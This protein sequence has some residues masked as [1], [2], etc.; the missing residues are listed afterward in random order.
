M[1]NVARDYAIKS[2]GNNAPTE[3]IDQLAWSRII[4]IEEAKREKL[5]VADKE[6]VEQLTSFPAFQRNG[7][8]DKKPFTS[9]SMRQ[10]YLC[11]QAEAVRPK[12]GCSQ[13]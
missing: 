5:R 6:V 11:R 7:G 4:L 3:F 8:F 13:P 9:A 10:L 2:L 1:W 12:A